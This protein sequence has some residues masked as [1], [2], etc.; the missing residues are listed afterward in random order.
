MCRA[1]N[2]NTVLRATGGGDGGVYLGKGRT[3]NVRELDY[4]KPGGRPYFVEK[5]GRLGLDD[6]FKHLPEMQPGAIRLHNWLADLM[7]HSRLL[8]LLESAKRKLHDIRGETVPKRDP[9]LPENY[10]QTVVY[11]PPRSPYAVQTWRVTEGTL[12]ILTD[13]ATPQEADSL[14]LHFPISMQVSADRQRHQDFMPKQ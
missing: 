5:D 6:S 14:L 12:L 10:I 13:Q 7:N 8:L 11:V 9:F 3:G 2:T 1:G 4:T